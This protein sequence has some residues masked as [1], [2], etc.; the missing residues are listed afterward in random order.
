MTKLTTQRS[1]ITA[2]ISTEEEE[3]KLDPSLEEVEEIGNLPT[4]SLPWTRKENL[5]LSGM[6]EAGGN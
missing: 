3:A 6:Q 1:G 4:D 2:K 5:P